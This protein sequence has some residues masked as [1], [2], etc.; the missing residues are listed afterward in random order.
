MI[1]KIGSEDYPKFRELLRQRCGVSAFEWLDFFESEREKIEVY[2]EG[3]SRLQSCM[4][5]HKGVNIFITTNSEKT[6]R[7]FLDVLGEDRGYAFRCP[8]W[9]APIVMEKFKPKEEDYKG[10][11]LL[12]YYTNEKLFKKYT[13]SKYVA[14]PL[15]EDV[16]EE[17]LPRLKRRFTLE[18][19]RER[20]RKDHFYGIYDQDKLISWVGTLWESKEACEIGFAYTKEEHR[21]KGLIKILTSVVTEKV[22]EEGKV[23]IL[24]TV[25]TNTAAVRACKALGY[26]LGAR[27]WA[28]FS[29]GGS[30]K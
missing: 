7:E 19:I 27:E 1:Y 21:G 20:I 30:K 15:L 12:T 9:M 5:L 6:L 23:P 3:R 13:D 24:H 16:A 28:Y 26:H 8:E 10:V 29:S 11:V 4:I 17:I 2:T 25:E 22:F 18:F 14:Q